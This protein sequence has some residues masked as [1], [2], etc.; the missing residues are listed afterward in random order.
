MPILNF[1]RKVS[2][3]NVFLFFGIALTLMLLTSEIITYFSPSLGTLNNSINYIE[4]FGKALTILVVV[5][6]GPVFE[7][8]L[9]QS[10][11]IHIIKAFVPKIRYS[12]FIS[13]FISSFVFG[14][15]H[16]YSLLYFLG[17]TLYGV[18]L[19]TVYY[20]SLFRKQSAFLLVFLLHATINFLALFMFLYK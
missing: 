6:F 3:L 2:K 1:I 7:T 19:A 20:V 4:H 11:I 17:A 12:F 13:I 8:I 10:L 5:V 15:S 18:I 9:Y 16:P 14:L